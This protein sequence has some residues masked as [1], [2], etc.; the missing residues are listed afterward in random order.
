MTKSQWIEKA[1]RSSGITK[2]NLQHAYDALEAA[3]LE[4][5]VSGESVQ[6]SGF[7]TFSARVQE[8]HSARNPKTNEIVQVPSTRRLTFIPGRTLKEKI[9]ET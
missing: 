4:T 7:G 9:N 2:K 3:L 5:L 8:P 6:I 1:A